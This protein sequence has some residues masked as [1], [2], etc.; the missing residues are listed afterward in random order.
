MLNLIILILVINDR[1][2]M[3]L[4]RSLEFIGVII[5]IVCSIEIQFE[6]S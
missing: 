3:A 4:N 5:Q 2:K 1:A 6:S